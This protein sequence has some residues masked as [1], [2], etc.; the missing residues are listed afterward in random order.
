MEG[1]QTDVYV[2]DLRTGEVRT[3]G[4]TGATG[5]T[6]TTGTTG[7]KEMLVEMMVM[8]ATKIPMMMMMKYAG[9]R[10]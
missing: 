7:A 4:P 8:G 6:G 10:V 2:M 9:A 5:I 1:E 3:T